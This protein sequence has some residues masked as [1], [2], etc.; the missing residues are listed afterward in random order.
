MAIDGA[1]GGTSGAPEQVTTSV[2]NLGWARFSADGRRLVAAAYER[3]AEL[4]LH[5]LTAGAAPTLEPLRTLRPRFL[6]WCQLSPDAE[7]LACA[8]I[9]TPEDLVLLRA[10]GSELRRLTDDPWKDRNFAW[11]SDGTRLAFD[12]TRS[13]PWQ[14]WTLRADG[15]EPRRITDFSDTVDKAW[16]RDGRRLTIS[17]GGE[18]L[19]EV[20]ADQLTPRAAMRSIPL[21]DS[22]RWFL[23][24]AW[25]PSG[26][27]LGGTEVDSGRRALSI[28]AFEPASG[29]YHRSRLPM[30]GPGWWRFA[31]W[32][33]DSRHFVA[34]GRDQVALVDVATG[35]WRGL[36]PSDESHQAVS[37]SSD[38]A[39]LL[40]ETESADGDI[41]L[42]ESP[43]GWK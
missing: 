21:P 43:D 24:G 1:T 18:G 27:L 5:R 35:A 28:G 4:H 26:E 40:V 12:S 6:H 9:G 22:M 41:W 31:G 39:T 38:A 23:P 19:A 14:L 17:T 7:W 32:L 33:P 16:S 25:S 34:L 3:S 13:G 8:T 10:D 11:S 36:L 15:S 2:G 20:D 30:S 42:L 37:L 29:T